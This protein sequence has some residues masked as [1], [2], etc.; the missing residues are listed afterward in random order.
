MI[1]V[2]F[3][4]GRHEPREGYANHETESLGSGVFA[5]GKR[6]CGPRLRIVALAQGSPRSV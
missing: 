4:A 5:G 3:E 2:A 6:F 1:P